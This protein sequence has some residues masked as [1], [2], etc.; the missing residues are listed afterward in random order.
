MSWEDLEDLI[1]DGMAAQ[2]KQ[3]HLYTGIDGFEMISHAFAV[4]NSVGFVRWM[5]GK[6]KI[7]S[8]TAKNLI[9]MLTSPDTENFNLAILAIEQ[10]KK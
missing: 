1:T 7:D 6:K 8:D 4:E 10:L 3:I 5:E 2:G 9:S